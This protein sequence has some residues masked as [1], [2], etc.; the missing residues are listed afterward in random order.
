M[1]KEKCF[2]LK[3]SNI[4]LWSALKASLYKTGFSVEVFCRIEISVLYVSVNAV[5]ELQKHIFLFVL[6]ALPHSS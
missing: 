3:G 6:Y 1:E 4:Q 5:L 2:C